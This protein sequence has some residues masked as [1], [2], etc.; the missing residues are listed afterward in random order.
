M[1]PAEFKK[2]PE[3]N[4]QNQS[5]HRNEQPSRK[6]HDKISQ[7]IWNIYKHGFYFF[8]LLPTFYTENLGWNNFHDVG[9]L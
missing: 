9:H 7:D 1:V 6:Y 5:I 2:A 3:L 4:Q 8:H